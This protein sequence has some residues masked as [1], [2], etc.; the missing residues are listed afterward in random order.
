MLVK[1]M[2]KAN[3]PAKGAIVQ[4]DLETFSIA[5]H[6]PGGFVEP[7]LLRKIADVAEKYGA[8]FVKLTGTQRMII[9]GIQEEDLDA[10]WAEFE[11]SSK[12][13][14]LTI[15]SIQMC[16]STRSCKRAKQ[17]SP[18]L[19][20][21]LD[22]EFYGKPAPA[23]FKMAVSG[24]PNC[25]S[26]PWMRDLGFVGTDDGFTAVVGGKGGGTAKVGRELAKGLTEEQALALAR[27]VIA[28][29]RENGQAPERLGATIERV[30]FDKFKE[31][32]L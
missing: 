29:Y 23:K 15:R 32:V 5:P 7:A 27:K 8:K 24:C 4:R 11:D 31:A 21:A 6:I 9:V 28:F 18:G 26:D 17:D 14:G 20:F 19:G 30:G 16:P 2:A 22:K 3:I 1:T 10:A 12:A 13:I 25:C